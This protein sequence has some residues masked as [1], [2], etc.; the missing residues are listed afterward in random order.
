MAFSNRRPTELM[1]FLADRR[2]DGGQTCDLQGGSQQKPA[3]EFRARDNG[4]SNLWFLALMRNWRAA[5]FSLRQRPDVHEVA[6]AVRDD[7]PVRGGRCRAAVQPSAEANDINEHGEN[8]KLGERELRDDPNLQDVFGG[9]CSAG[10]S[11]L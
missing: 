7:R 5:D 3:V 2:L 10:Y 11:L 6:R 4:L 9:R 8:S 1:V